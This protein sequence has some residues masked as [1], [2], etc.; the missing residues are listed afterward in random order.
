MQRR[1]R[2]WALEVLEKNKAAVLQSSHLLAP[3][4]DLVSALTAE[5][6]RELTTA[7]V[8][9]LMCLS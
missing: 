7:D 3:A 9:L 5:L 6:V 4:V 2:A 8:E 1:R